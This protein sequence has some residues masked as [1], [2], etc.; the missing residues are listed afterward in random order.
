MT[1]GNKMKKKHKNRLLLVLILL[2]VGIVAFFSYTRVYSDEYALGLFGPLRSVVNVQFKDNDET[3]GIAFI[4]ALNR[5]VEF[6]FDGVP[7]KGKVIQDG[8]WQLYAGAIHP[9]KKGAKALPVGCDDEKFVTFL[10]LKW[11]H[12][13]CGNDWRDAERYNT[14]NFVRMV[15]ILAK[16]HPEIE[17]RIRDAKPA[18]V[19]TVPKTVKK[20]K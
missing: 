3:V 8:E 1:K 9:N 7:R 18:P 16:R 6:A 17:S 19:K 15:D 20:E 11:L 12:Q 14:A 10:V 13:E 4:D 2:I 5:R